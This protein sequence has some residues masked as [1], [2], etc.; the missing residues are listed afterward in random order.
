MY[1]VPSV[2]PSEAEGSL[3]S[4]E[5]SDYPEGIVLAVDKPYRWWG[6]SRSF[7]SDNGLSAKR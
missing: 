7:L 2:I 1:F 6:Y 4:R 3:L 5:I